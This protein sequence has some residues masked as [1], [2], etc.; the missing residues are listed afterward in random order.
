M[1]ELNDSE[2][3]EMTI[4]ARETVRILLQ[5]FEVSGFNWTIQEGEEAGQS[6]PHL[7]L[8]L[9]PRKPLDLPQPGDWY[10]LLRKTQTDV[11]DSDERPRLQK[12]EMMTIVAKIRATT[13]KINPSLLL[14]DV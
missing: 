14:L 7:H 13:K 9:I 6:V 10:P 11:I 3:C 12:E 8:H 5:T 4:F 2:L 1:M